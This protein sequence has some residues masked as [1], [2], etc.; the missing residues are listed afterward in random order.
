VKLFFFQLPPFPLL[1]KETPPAQNPHFLIA[2]E[3]VLVQE[4]RILDQSN[5]N[6]SS[7]DSDSFSFTGKQDGPK[8]I[9]K[10]FFCSC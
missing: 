4:Q 10:H 3:A 6:Q 1:T 7:L 2:S 5:M 9:I 8:A